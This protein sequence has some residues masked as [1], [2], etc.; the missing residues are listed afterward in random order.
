MKIVP[1]SVPFAPP[2]IVKLALAPALRLMSFAVLSS[3]CL[4]CVAFCA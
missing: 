1:E 2:L 3:I 4:A